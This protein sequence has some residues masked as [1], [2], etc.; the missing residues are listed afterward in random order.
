[1]FSVVYLLVSRKALVDSSEAMATR[2]ATDKL[3]ESKNMGKKE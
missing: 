3:S 1:M 2:M